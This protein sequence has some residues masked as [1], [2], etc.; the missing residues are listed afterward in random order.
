MKFVVLFCDDVEIYKGWMEDIK[1]FI[2]IDILDFFYFIIVDK[3][4]EFVV[5]FG[6]IDFEEKDF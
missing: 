4:W 3:G 6:M 2:K 1:V 5:R